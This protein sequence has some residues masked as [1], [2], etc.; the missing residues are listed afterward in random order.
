MPKTNANGYPEYRDDYLQ[1]GVTALNIF[2]GNRVKIDLGSVQSTILV[3]SGGQS[4]ESGVS[5][6]LLK[7]TNSSNSLEVNN[8]S[9]G[10][11]EFG[12][13]AGTLAVLKINGGTVFVG[14]GA[15][16]SSCT[17]TIGGGATEINSNISTVVQTGGTLEINGA[18]TVASL[19][20]GTGG[21]CNYNSS[22]T[23]TAA[24][25]RG[26]LDLSGDTSAVTFTDLTLGAGARLI[27]PHSRLIVTNKTLWADD[28][29]EVTV[30]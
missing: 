12:G 6:V 29:E 24:V 9:V 20:V 27:D 3:D 19:T 15:T 1:V 13:E 18:A 23:C 2:G 17:A 8:G 11:A 30:S 5:A 10:F 25:I 21:T 22:G 7:G 16:L 28:V 4:I 26:T 14:A